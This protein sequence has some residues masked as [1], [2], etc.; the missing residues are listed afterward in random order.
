LW[1][2]LLKPHAETYKALLARRVDDPLQ[3][4]HLC[5]SRRGKSFGGAWTGWINQAHGTSFWPVSKTQAPGIPLHNILQAGPPTHRQPPERA[6]N[7]ISNSPPRPI[8]A[9][10]TDQGAGVFI[11]ATGELFVLFAVQGA[12]RTLE[13]AHINVDQRVDDEA[14]FHNIR[15]RYKEKRGFLRY[16]LSIWQLKDCEMAMVISTYNIACIMY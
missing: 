16:W 12:R 7:P 5:T 8:P 1:A 3:R 2:E 14:F 6:R 4:R 13:L 10:A 9:T 11:Q 15:I